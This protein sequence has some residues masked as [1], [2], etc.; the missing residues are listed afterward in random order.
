MSGC[1]SRKVL[2][3][4]RS[5]STDSTAAST[6]ARDRTNFTRSRAGMNG[7][8]F[9]KEACLSLLTMTINLSPRSFDFCKYSM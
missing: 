3:T 7:C 8:P 2:H 6:H 5:S 1:N 4:E 9:F